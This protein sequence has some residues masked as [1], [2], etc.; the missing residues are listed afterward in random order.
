MS[1]VT[2]GLAEKTPN[3]LSPVSG[4]DH[5]FSRVATLDASIFP[6]TARVLL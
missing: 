4:T 2:I 5:A 6:P 1:S 3:V